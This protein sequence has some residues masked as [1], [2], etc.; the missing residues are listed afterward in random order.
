MFS[1]LIVLVISLILLGLVHWV[2]QKLIDE[3][4]LKSI[5]HVVIVVLAVLACVVFIA[6]VFGVSLPFHLRS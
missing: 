2:A 6:D 5:A 4:K 3:A 1:S